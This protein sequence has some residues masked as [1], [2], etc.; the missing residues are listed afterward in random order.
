MR[1]TALNNEIFFKGKIMKKSKKV[2]A[3]LLS[4]CM[5]CA[6]PAVISGCSDSGDDSHKTQTENKPVKIKDIENVTLKAGGQTEIT[7]S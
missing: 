1:F 5:V 4:A 7:G 2:L 3:F 6:I